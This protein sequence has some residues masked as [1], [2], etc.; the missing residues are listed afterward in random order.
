VG[1][2]VEP[3]DGVVEV[4]DA[5]PGRREEGDAREDV[6][7]RGQ[8]GGTREQH[9]GEDEEEEGG[10]DVAERDDGDDDA[11]GCERADSV[12]TE[13]REPGR[14]SGQRLDHG[15]HLTVPSR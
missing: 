10:F 3:G 4:G 14:A 9:A 11:D 15:S 12:G 8:A 7:E 1:D 6:E 13:L 2:E 5:E